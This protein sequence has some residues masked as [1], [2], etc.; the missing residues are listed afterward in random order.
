MGGAGRAAC[1]SGRL[2]TVM[3][4]ALKYNDRLVLDAVDEAV[5]FINAA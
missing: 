1:G 3:P 4:K 5:E 2:I